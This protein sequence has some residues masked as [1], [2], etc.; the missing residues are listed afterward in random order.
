MKPKTKL[1][2]TEK[3]KLKIIAKIRPNGNKVLHD[4][5]IITPGET[6]ATLAGPHEGL[7]CAAEVLSTC[8]SCKGVQSL[9]RQPIYC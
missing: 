3:L 9:P 7:S 6:E 2:L 1:K 8:G 5:R 4:K